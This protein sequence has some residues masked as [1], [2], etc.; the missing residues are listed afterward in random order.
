MLSRSITAI[1]NAFYLIEKDK[2]NIFSTFSN[3]FFLFLRKD[4]LFYSHRCG[5]K[6]AI[7]ASMSYN[8]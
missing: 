3:F 5:L 6:N 4:R 2:S 8:I 7:G 1:N